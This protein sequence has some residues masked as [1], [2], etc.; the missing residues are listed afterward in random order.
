VPYLRDLG[1][2]ISLEIEMGQ[3]PQRGQQ[4][5][6]RLRASGTDLSEEAILELSAR[7]SFWPVPKEFSIRIAPGE[8]HEFPG[9]E[10]LSRIAGSHE[11]RFLVTLKSVRNVPFGRWTVSQVLTI[12]DTQK[13]AAAPLN[14]NGGDIFVFGGLGTPNPLLGLQGLPRLPGIGTTWQALVLRPDRTFQDWL[15]RTCPEPVSGCPSVPPA[16]QPWTHGATAHARIE[17]RDQQ[18]GR[19]RVVAVVCGQVAS[20]GRGGNSGVAWWLQPEP[21]TE[22]QHRRL[23]REHTIITLRDGRAWVADQGTN[24]TWLNSQ[25]LKRGKAELLASGD[26]LDLAGVVKLSIA[27]VANQGRV[28]VV[29]V[30]RSDGLAGRLSYMLT[31]G[32]APVLVADDIAGPPALWLAWRRGRSHG[33][34]LAIFPTDG[35]AWLTVEP[36]QE[37]PINP[38]YRLRWQLL[39]T[40]QEQ[41]LY[42]PR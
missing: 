4:G 7:T 39:A 34:E 37:R 8:T 24:G 3:A 27:L 42:L 5:L 17:L 26:Q 29:W 9:L 20:L 41:D 1:A 35:S 38:W 21:Y 18:T 15:A 28:H 40:P 25:P 23:S 6:L 2:P 33:L 32:L 16:E 10:F 22:Q 19:T 14:S 13:S 36:G 11:I 12:E 31:N 30:E